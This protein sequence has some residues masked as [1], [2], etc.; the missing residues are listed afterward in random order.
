[1][2]TE[3]YLI[4]LHGGYFDGYRQSV[5]YILLDNRLEMPGM[6]PYPDGL[7]SL[8]QTALYEFRQASIEVF[9]G[10]PTMVLDYD[11]I[12]KRVGRVSA[13]IAKLNQW[14]DRVVRSL[15]RTQPED[16][17]QGRSSSFSGSGHS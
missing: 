14:K 2:M 6:L 4:K 9:D 10:L 17:H 13:A 7:P 16:N 12:G 1:M 11:Y 8:L 15:L 5:N 3:I